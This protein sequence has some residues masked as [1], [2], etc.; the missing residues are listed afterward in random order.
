MYNSRITTVFY[1]LSRFTLFIPV[2]SRITRNPFQTLLDFKS[3]KS[4]CGLNRY[5]SN[6]SSKWVQWIPNP[7]LDLSK[8]TENPFLDSKYGQIRIWILTKGKYPRSHCIK[9]IT[10]RS[11]E[12]NCEILRTIFQPRELFSR[13]IQA[14]QKGVYLFYNPPTDFYKLFEI[15][16][17]IKC[18]LTE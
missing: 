13:H 6:P 15:G 10:W 7:F 11:F 18:L 12:G 4:G 2:N 9:H 16:H 3:K 1:L 5:L 14:S 8:G 17:M